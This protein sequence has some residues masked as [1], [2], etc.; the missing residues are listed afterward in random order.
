MSRSLFDRTII[1][2][3]LYNFPNFL[4]RGQINAYTGFY[5]KF[6]KYFHEYITT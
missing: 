5:I 2:E 6:I 4:D 1:I 3:G